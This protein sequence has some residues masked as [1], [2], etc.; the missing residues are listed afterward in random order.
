MRAVPPASILL[1][2]ACAGLLL[3][4]CAGG[5]SPPAGSWLHPSFG[6]GQLQRRTV[7][8]FP[9]GSVTLEGAA[10]SDSVAAALA[11]QAVEALAT[12]AAFVSLPDDEV[13]ALYDPLTSAVLESGQGGE[14]PGEASVRW[15]GVA[16]RFGERY[17]LVPRSLSIERLEPLRVRAGL[18]AWL[19][20]A[21]AALV[22]WHAQVSA[23]NPHAPSGTAAD[24]YAAA[25]EDAVEAVAATVA[26]RLARLGRTGSDRFEDSVP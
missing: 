16:N 23:T 22:L 1:L 14:L 15:R 8:V 4:A 10:L 11:M 12:V 7:V 19:L 20:D 25:L 9:V 26:S 6:A 13:G 21:S 2:A 17:F 3:E 18:D 5:A 24:V